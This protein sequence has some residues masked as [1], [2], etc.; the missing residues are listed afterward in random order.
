MFLF[1]YRKLVCLLLLL[2][3]LRLESVAQPDNTAAADRIT[4]H[5]N[6]SNLYGIRLQAQTYMRNTEYFNNI[7]LGRTLF[8]YQ[9]NPSFYIQPKRHLLLQTGF[10]V[11]NDFG[12]KTPYTLV[13]PTFTLKV[14]NALS[15]VLFG[16][17]EG[18]WAHG[19]AEPLFDINS[20]IDRHLENGFQY[21]YVP[22]K[23]KTDFWVNWE[24]FIERGSPFKEQFTAGFNIRPRLY[25]RSA[26]FG[27]YL[28]VQFTAFHRGG[29]IDTDTSNMVMVFNGG[30]GLEAQWNFA[31]TFLRQIGLSTMSMAY[32]EN[33]NSGYFP[34]RNGTGQY[35]N[36]F[37]KLGAFHFMLSHWSG[38]Q[39]IAP[40]GTTI[41]Q[42]V[43]IDKPGY[44]EQTRKLLF[45]RVFYEQ[46][47][48]PELFLSVRYEPFID[49]VN[50]TTDFSYSVYLTYRDHFGLGHL[51]HL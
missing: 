25:Q 50:H 24:R 40:R 11:R 17:L 39:F 15:Y 12:G 34:F 42:S 10:Y 2:I 8:G 36:L 1:P 35:T 47:I 14:G 3:S 32:R 41:Y 37:C 38:T 23:C 19:L 5:D 20:N 16:T 9:F 51:K 48:V 4:L 46:E 31:G 33:S 43:S 29:Q 21:R 44:S 27:L 45:F 49:L 6:D 28:P 22:D 7:E 13:V 26:R 18:A 30:A